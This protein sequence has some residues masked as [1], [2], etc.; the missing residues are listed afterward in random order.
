MT[1][2]RPK[3]RDVSD[4]SGKRRVSLGELQR[5]LAQVAPVEADDF[6]ALA[7]SLSRLLRPDGGDG[8]KRLD[9]RAVWQRVTA[10]I[11][12]AEAESTE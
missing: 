6:E 9:K 8:V 2:F 10:E 3:V 11:D 12:L 7:E 4:A 5:E 1:Q